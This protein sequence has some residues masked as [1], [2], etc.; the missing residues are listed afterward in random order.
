[1]PEL[2]DLAH[3]KQYIDATSLHRHIQQIRQLDSDLLDG[4]SAQ[5]FD[6]KLCGQRF[7]STARHGKFLFVRLDSGKHLLMHFG[8]TGDLKSSKHGEAT[9]KHTR[10]VFVLD[11]DYHLAYACQRKL[12]RLGLVE[13]PERF[14]EEQELGPDA[15]DD[16]LDQPTFR[17]RL[18]GRRGSIKSSLMNQ[19]VVAGLGNIYSDEVLFQAGIHPEERVDELIASSVE[20]LYWC[21]RDVLAKASQ[22]QAKVDRL[23]QGF[24]LPHRHEDGHCPRCDTK[25]AKV[26]ISGRHAWI[27]PNCQR[28]RR[29]RGHH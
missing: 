17:E 16:S 15:L 12:G 5:R 8:M 7:E 21:M 2:P 3:F 11:D 19:A 4:I 6:K 14:V 20:A 28:K 26:A 24:L 27:C 13:N 18:Q 29:K 9:P 22:R 25:L 23:P 10:C 1:M